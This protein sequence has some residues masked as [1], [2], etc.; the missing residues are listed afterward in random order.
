MVAANY[1]G[2]DENVQV[3]GFMLL[4]DMTGFG[5]K[6]LTHWTID[7]MRKWNNYWQA[8]FFPLQTF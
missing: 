7:D 2:Q 4:I 1:A 6:H 5:A 3:S 8:S